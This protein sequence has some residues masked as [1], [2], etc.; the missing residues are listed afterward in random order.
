MEAKDINLN[1]IG[2]G[3]SFPPV[4]NKTIK[5]V[6][7]REGN[8]DIIESLNILLTT[9][10]GERIYDSNFGCDLSP[11]LFEPFTNTLK[12]SLSDRIKNAI[13]LFEAR[14]VVENIIFRLSSEEGIIYI[15]INYLIKSHNS[16]YN[17]VFP[18]YLK[19]G[20]EL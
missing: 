6:E 18:Y 16:R 14:I 7:Q 11:L 10:P 8:D 2:K 19:E 13:V 12:S 20:T 3:W 1:F 9:L 15:S 4:F 17:M 5:G